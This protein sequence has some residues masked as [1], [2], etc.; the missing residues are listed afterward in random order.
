MSAGHIGLSVIATDIGGGFSLGL[1]G[2]G[3]TIGL[4]GSWLLFTGLVGSWM[5]AV[6]GIPQIKKLSDATNM[7]TYPD[8]LKFHYGKHVAMIAALVSGFGYLGFTSSQILAGAKLASGS[9]LTDITFIDP[10]TLSLFIMAITI[11]VYTVLGGIKAVIYTDTIQWIVLFFGLLLFGLPFTYFQLGG[12]EVIRASL[13]DEYF[14][15]TN[16]SV[17]TVINWSITIIPVWFIAMTL[18]QRIFACKDVKEAKKAFYLAGLLEYPLMAFVGVA[19]GMLAK[20]HA[21][22]VEA[23]MGIP[24]LLRDILPIGVSGIVLAAYFSAIMSTADSCLIASSGNFLNDI[25]ERFWKK[26]ISETQLIKLSKLVTALVG[27]LALFIAAFFDT[28]LELILHTYS[29]M[30]AGLFVPTIMI[31]FPKYINRKAAFYSIL[32]GGGSALLLIFSGINLPFGLK[33]SIYGILLSGFTYGLV[34][35]TERKVSLA[36]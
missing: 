1:G 32:S 13:P 27:V 12:W 4:S 20:V 36:N 6:W 8:F 14:S 35:F 19:L 15:L 25:I 18:Y 2:L 30:I 7:L 23:E 28:I 3:F 22:T 11:I 34:F 16:I 9:I 21:P 24:V 17:I 5:L 10:M 33:A 31:F 29:F 26:R